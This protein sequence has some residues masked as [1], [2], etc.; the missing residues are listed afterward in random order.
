VGETSRYDVLKEMGF[1]VV[2]PV[3]NSPKQR[4][5]AVERFL[6]KYIDG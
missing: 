4:I 2:R 1:V 6:T 5:E 3:T